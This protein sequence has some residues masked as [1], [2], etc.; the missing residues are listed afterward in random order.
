MLHALVNRRNIAVVVAVAAVGLA[1]AGLAG[2]DVEIRGDSVEILIDAHAPKTVETAASEM[3]AFLGRV[4]CA[5]I[6][7][8]NA[9]T[10]GKVSIVL[11]SN[12]W[13]VAAGIDTSS[14]KRDAFVTKVEGRRIYIAGRDD[15]KADIKRGLSGKEYLPQFERAT[16]FGVYAFLEDVAGCRFFFPG[17][18]GTVVPR[19]KRLVVSEGEKTTAPVF[20]VRDPYLHFAKAA[21][22]GETAEMTDEER[23]AMRRRQVGLDWLRMRLQTERIPCCHGQNGF[24][25]TDRF[26]ET[27]PEYLRLKQDGTRAT[28]LEQNGN[29]YFWQIRHL[30]HTS[31]VWDEMYE[32]VKSYL[33]GQPASVRGI[34]SQW[35]NGKFGWNGNCVGRK[36]VDIMPQDG[37]QRCCCENCKKAY[38][39]ERNYATDLVW[40]QT[41]KLARRLKA[42]GVKGYVTQMAYTP[43]GRVPDVELPDNVLVMVARTGP[44]MAR[45]PKAMEKELAD[46]RAWSKK[47]GGKVWIW[48]YPHKYGSTAIPDV[49]CMAPKAW[50]TY[51]QRAAPWIFGSFAECET[52]RAIFNYL[53]CYVF[54]KIA[55]DPGLDLDALLDDHYA[56]MFGAGAAEMKAFYEEMED[57]WLKVAGNIVWDEAGPQAT[58]PSDYTLA[59]EIYSPKRLA[60]WA[61]LCDKAVE[62]NAADPDAQ[63]RVSFIKGEFVDRLAGSFREYMD[64][65]SVE[66]ALKRRAAEPERPNLVDPKGWSVYPSKGAVPIVDSAVRGPTGANAFHIR[67]SGNKAYLTGTL[68]RAPYLLKP[69]T[70]YRLSCFMKANGVVPLQRGGIYMEINNGSKNWAE[71]GK[72]GRRFSGTTD[73]VYQEMEFETIGEIS[74]KAFICF[75][76]FNASGEAWFD[77][78]RLE[79]MGN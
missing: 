27:H 30:C 13:S 44:W 67:A 65:I 10:D 6:P 68:R 50:G 47:V 22:P 17:E 34:P 3:C 55:W 57:A 5:K 51:Y 78:I 41:A 76:I 48:T 64:E 39:D 16:L 29:R 36:Y 40:G 62:K 54:S 75:R 25:Y 33:T 79:E 8:V 59:C 23:N 45:E 1:S 26:R 70:K 77:G 72:G 63:S 2:S 58:V 9:P 32:D 19:S 14:L 38:T 21:R 35:S 11:G 20:T 66:K 73:W 52:D 49:P 56:K 24:M 7:V 4:L 53:N 43:Y 31:K 18:F 15:P 42:E 61:K 12:D 60:R 74:P 71:S 69:N 37:F 28:E 46:Y